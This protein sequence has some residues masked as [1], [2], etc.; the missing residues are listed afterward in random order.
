MKKYWVVILIPLILALL[1]GACGKEQKSR[2]I[3]GEKQLWTC[4]MHPEVIVEQPGNCPICGMKLVP[5]KNTTAGVTTTNKPDH[6]SENK[7]VAT[8]IEQQNKEA[9]DGKKKG[10]KILYWRAP[11]DPTYISDKPGKSPMGMDLIPVYEG[12]EDLTTGPTVVIDPVVVQN[13]GVRTAKVEKRPLY[14][15][16]RTVGHLDYNEEKIYRVNVKFSGWIE[17]LYVDETGQEVYKGQ[18]MLEIYSPELVTTQEEYL[19]ALKNAKKL[20]E[21]PFEEISEGT[22]SLLEATRRRLLYWDITEQQI[23]DLEEKGII[24]KTMA[25]YSPVNGVVIE[26][27]A[28][29]GMHVMPGTDL[30]RIADLSTIW[31]YVHIYEYELPW[32]KPGQQVEMDLPYIP[33]EVFHGRVDYIY[34]YLDAKTRD[35]KL[36]LVFPNPDLR[37]KPQMYANIQI[38]SKLGDEVVAIPDEA[39]IHSGKRNIVF[40]AKGGGK[41]EPREV[42]LGALADGG[43]YQVIAGLKPGEEVVTSAQFLLDSESRLKEAI[44]KMLELRKKK[45]NEKVD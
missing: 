37:L 42:V 11:M 25:L 39:V 28:E 32:V 1:L 23:K 14:R 18:P 16:I 30:Y 15:V 35:V 9:K 3:A 45:T 26:K 22:R 33:G 5:V 36:R 41:F 17:K 7:I 43:F 8:V 38:K 6:E 21:S 34:P 29:V 20:S 24:T 12:E 44:Q 31:V 4:A 13:I 2:E 27:K 19:L 40:V 10:K